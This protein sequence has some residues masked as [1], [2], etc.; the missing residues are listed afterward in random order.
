MFHLLSFVTTQLVVRLAVVYHCIH[1]K[2]S[3]LTVKKETLNCILQIAVPR[4]VEL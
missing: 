2:K 4:L 1:G 3:L